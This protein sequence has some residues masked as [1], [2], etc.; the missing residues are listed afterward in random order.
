[1]LKTYIFCEQGMGE[2]L[3]CTCDYCGY[4]SSDEVLNESHMISHIT[5]Y[6][7]LPFH[8]CCYCNDGFINVE[9]LYN[10]YQIH[11]KMTF[12]CHLCPA[13]FIR[14]DILKSHLQSHV[15]KRIPFKCSMCKY[16]GTSQDDINCHVTVEHTP[17]YNRPNEIYKKQLPKNK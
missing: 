4:R 10:H 13:K 8:G 12:C 6:E 7:G 5:Y 1:M 11:M 15:N 16:H 9:D 3:A 2:V 17:L 14:K